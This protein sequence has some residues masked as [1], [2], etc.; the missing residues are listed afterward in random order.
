MHQHHQG[1][2]RHQLHAYKASSPQNTGDSPESEERG[3][4]PCGDRSESIVD[5]K[6]DSGGSGEEGGGE[7]KGLASLRDDGEE[8]NASEITLKF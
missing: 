5:G 2:F 8:S 7:R 3:A 6:S 4:G 1:L